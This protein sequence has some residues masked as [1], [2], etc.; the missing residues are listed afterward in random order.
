MGNTYLCVF[1]FLII[2]ICK[3]DFLVIYMFSY[4]V[5]EK[6]CEVGFVFLLNIKYN[7]FFSLILN[8]FKY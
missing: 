7:F 4:F 6:Q 3:V 5:L 2:Y 1:F 8:S